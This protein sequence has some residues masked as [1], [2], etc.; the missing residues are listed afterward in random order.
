MTTTRVAQALHRWYSW[1]HRTLP[2][3]DVASVTKRLLLDQLAFAPLFLP[4][5][6]T[7]LLC[8][9]SHPQPVTEARAQ[10]WPTLVANWKLWVPAQLVNFGLVP[11]H[12][13]ARQGIE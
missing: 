13:Q 1:L 4:L 12:F 9:E 5:F 11:P 7:T 8:I 2:G 6:V 10:W 3:T